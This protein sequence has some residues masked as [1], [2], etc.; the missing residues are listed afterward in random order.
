MRPFVLI[1]AFL[2]WSLL[3]VRWGQASRAVVAREAQE[4]AA[5][6]RVLERRLLKVTLDVLEQ[7]DSTRAI[8]E[9]MLRRAR[10]PRREP[11]D[12]GVTG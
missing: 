2:L 4:I 10:P 5:E 11:L 7:G 9:R 3:M 8:V 1:G 6:C 12:E